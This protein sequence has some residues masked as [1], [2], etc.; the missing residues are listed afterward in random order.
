MESVLRPFGEV[1]CEE[2]VD[3]LGTRYQD[4]FFYDTPF[5][6]KALD[7]DC[8]LIVGRRGSGKTTLANYFNF[9]Q[10]I[11]GSRCIDVDEPELYADLVRQLADRVSESEDLAIPQT[12]K[13]WQFLIWHL[14]F[15]QM[16]TDHSEIKA[17]CRFFDSR[18][19]ARPVGLLTS[20]VRVNK[21]ETPGLEV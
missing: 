6:D 5:N 17:A 20:T 2:E 7:R 8:Y 3:K 14:I 4:Y 11:P 10:G 21:N 13:I 18:T 12:A 15:E 1:S 16:S 9:Q 19:S